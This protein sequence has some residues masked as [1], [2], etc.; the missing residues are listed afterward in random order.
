MIFHNR[1]LND[2]DKGYYDKKQ[3]SYHIIKTRFFVLKSN[4][5]KALGICISD[6]D[7][8]IEFRWDGKTVDNILEELS[9]GF[10]AIR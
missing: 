2:Y 4:I 7:M 5:G 10:E 9:T 1:A 8:W 3:L 6:R